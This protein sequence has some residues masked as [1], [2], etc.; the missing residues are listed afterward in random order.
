MGCVFLLV[1][2]P[3]AVVGAAAWVYVSTKE[4]GE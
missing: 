1:V 3:L 4:A 2:M